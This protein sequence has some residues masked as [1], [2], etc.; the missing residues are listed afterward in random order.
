MN[1][2]LCAEF[3]EHVEALA[4]GELAEPEASRLLA[5][6]GSC[7]SCQAQL[8][9]V[10]GLVDSLLQLTPRVEPPAGF[11]SR[12]LGRLHVG[13]SAPAALWRSFIVAAA[14]IAALLGG[15]ALGNTALS[16]ADDSANVSA[17]TVARSGT[18]AARDG[19]SLGSAQL[20]SGAEP[21]VLVTIDNPTNSSATVWCELVLAS[22]Q[23]VTVGSW[24]YDDVAA[25]VWAVGIDRALLQAGD[26]RIVAADGSVVATAVLE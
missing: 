26:M 22:G 5:H 2:E 12:V 14:C 13:T 25:G 17:G 16:G 21:F 20:V 23:S 4:I 6:A 3:E 18:I 19:S 1:T 7:P 11:E 8:D 24:G 10:S 15:V 9:T